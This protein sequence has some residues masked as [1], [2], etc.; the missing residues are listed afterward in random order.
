MLI[1]CGLWQE[2]R[3]ECTSKTRSQIIAGLAVGESHWVDVRW[4]YQSPCV[5]LMAAQQKERIEAANVLMSLKCKLA[6]QML[7][8]YG[9]TKPN[10][11]IVLD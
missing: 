4:E 11:P 8:G 6:F 10:R 7:G 5:W 1:K 2:P 9:L 3:R